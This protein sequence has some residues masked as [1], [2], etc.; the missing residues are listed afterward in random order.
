MDQPPVLVHTRARAPASTQAWQA[1]RWAAL[2][3]LMLSSSM[4]RSWAAEDAEYRI[5]AAFLCKFGNYVDW[6]ETTWS[7]PDASFVIGVLGPAPL[8][9]AVAA[10][11]SGQAVNGRPI[12]VRRVER[13]EAMQGLNILFVARTHSGRLPEALAAVKDQPVLVVTEQE[14][15]APAGSMVNFVVAEDKVKFD[16]WP[17][18]AE[19][20]HLRISARL[21]GVARH[22][23][24]GAP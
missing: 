24:G 22:V 23:G 12:T 11:A 3:A 16:V 9:D 7:T 5:K 20:N 15:T 13:L 4:Q 10:A 2:F 6:P 18:A 8:V 21:L 1:L 14:G 17:A 19:R